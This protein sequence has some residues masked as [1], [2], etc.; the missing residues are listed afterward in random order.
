ML[1]NAIKKSI[2]KPY[3]KYLN[4][5]LTRSY[6]NK[7]ETRKIFNNNYK[8][9]RGTVRSKADYDEGW[10]LF[11]SFKSKVVFDI[12]CN[13]GYSTLLIAQSETVNKIVAV[14]PNPLSLSIA[15]ENL[16]LN[17][18]SSNVVFIPK[19]AH[20]KSGKKIQLWS[21]PGPFAAASTNMDFSE[22]GAMA[23]T[24]IDV[25]TITLDDIAATY[26]LWPDLIKIDVEGAEYS[27]LEGSLKIAENI[28]T[29]FI[30]EVHS[31]DS[32]S[33]VENTE[34]ILVWCKENNFIAY[35]LCE[36]IELIDSNIIDSRGRY[37]LL[38]IH[39][40][41]KYPDGLNEIHQSEDIKNIIINNN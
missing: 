28:G 14:E 31:C 34:K 19:A 35:Y 40:D 39:K 3:I 9:I 29:K 20:R 30:V 5:K 21:M 24:C 41:D 26:D 7:Y 8:V 33:I 13:V 18:L 17:D 22:S 23:K 25:E 16:I 15:A 32:L 2:K 1:F 27:V 38:L 4:K 11:L 37:H 36:H 12:G 6:N 10:I